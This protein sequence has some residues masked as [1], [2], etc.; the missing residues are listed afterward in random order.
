[1]RVLH[2]DTL[3]D[4]WVVKEPERIYLGRNDEKRG[5]FEFITDRVFSQKLCKQFFGCDFRTAEQLW[6]R[7]HVIDNA[8]MFLFLHFCY[9][10]MSCEYRWKPSRV[11]SSK[12]M[13]MSLYWHANERAKPYKVSPL[14]LLINF[15]QL[16]CHYVW[17][18]LLGYWTV[19]GV[20]L[21]TLKYHRIVDL[22]TR[23]V[24]AR[25]MNGSNDRWRALNV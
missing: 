7:V 15:I 8:P 11:F 25:D 22:Y 24:N 3:T 17:F 21:F 1:M 12:F 20:L 16:F 9:F 6:T 5:V 10:L 4:K 19:I 18:Y 14:S 2:C 23:I 13:L